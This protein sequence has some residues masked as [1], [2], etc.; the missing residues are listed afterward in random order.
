MHQVGHA[1]LRNGAIALGVNLEEHLV[2]KDKVLQLGLAPLDQEVVDEVLCL[3][4]V[5]EASFLRVVLRPQGL[6]RGKD[7]IVLMHIVNA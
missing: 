2:E 3:D 4:L 6:D 5:N 7:L 1:L